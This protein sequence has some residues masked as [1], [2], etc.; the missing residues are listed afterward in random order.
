MCGTL[1]LSSLGEVALALSPASPWD[2]SRSLY[3]GDGRGPRLCQHHPHSVLTV[4]HS[5]CWD[6][7]PVEG[8]FGQMYD[9][10]NNSVSNLSQEFSASVVFQVGVCPLFPG[11]GW[12]PDP[13]QPHGPSAA[14]ATP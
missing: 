4:M 7:I 11:P 9:L 2:G 6:K 13:A 5:W 8:N 14:G 12:G 1:A 10:V 3:Q